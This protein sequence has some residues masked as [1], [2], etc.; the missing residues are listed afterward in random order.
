MAMRSLTGDT[1]AV[2]VG[3]DVILAH[4]IGDLEGLLNLV[5]QGRDAKIFLIVAVVDHDLAAA[6][7]HVQ[8]GDR[9]FSSA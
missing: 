7:F 5:L 3:L 4:Q 1:A 8:T 9:S 6:R 2:Q